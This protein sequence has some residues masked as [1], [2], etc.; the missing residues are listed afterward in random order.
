MDI[1]EIEEFI[2]KTIKKIII[3]DDMTAIF[4]YCEDGSQYKMYHKKDCSEQVWLSDIS[5][6]IGDIVGYPILTAEGRCERND[7]ERSAGID[8]D[9]ILWTFY[10]FAT[11]KG[12]VT[13]RWVGRSNG[14][15]AED[16]SIEKVCEKM[17]Q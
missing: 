5:G 9:R 13:L 10:E 8:N 7:K 17:I 1:I 16:V 6:D 14:H 12:S 4:F 3:L 15:Y 2:G 11:V